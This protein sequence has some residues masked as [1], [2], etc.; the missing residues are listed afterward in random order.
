MTTLPK[1]DTQIPGASCLV[2]LATATLANADLTTHAQTL[3]HD[4]LTSMKE[5]VAKH[6]RAK[7]A[8]ALVIDEYI[9]LDALPSFDGGGENIAKKDFTAVGKKYN[10]N[11][12]LVI[13][14]KALGFIRTYSAY[15][16]TSDPKAYLNGNGY[17]VDMKTNAYDWYLP[18]VVTKSADG[19]WD[20]PPTF[21]GLTNAYFQA[22]EIAKDTLLKP[23]KGEGVPTAT[24]GRAQSP[25]AIQ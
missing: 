7:G 6:L 14:M 11:R 13:E 23:I 3:P 21:P 5:T 4:D 1:L 20:E 25:S 8:D 9:D 17:L 2:C 12:L 24:L 10:I 22:V 18:V 19:K 16:P 15:I